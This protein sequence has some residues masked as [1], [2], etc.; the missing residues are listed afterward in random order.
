VWDDTDP[1]MM[2]RLR[3]DRGAIKFVLNGA[4]IMC[5]G[6]TS[7]GATM[8]DEVEEG[9]PVVRAHPLRASMPPSGCYT[10][11][12]D[13]S[14][15]SVAPVRR[16]LRTGKAPGWRS[17][18]I[19]AEGKEHAVALGVTTMSTAEMYDPSVLLRTNGFSSDASS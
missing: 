19:Y 5:P 4:D 18:A 17:Q 3:V 11:M 6:L 12:C 8:H 13:T 15:V 9:T 2:N 16:R 14:R 10:G 1:M 7:P